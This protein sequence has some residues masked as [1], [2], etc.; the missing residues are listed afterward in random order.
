LNKLKLL[1][2]DYWEHGRV[3]TN[4]DLALD[5][6]AAMALGFALGKLL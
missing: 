1:F 4:G 2:R 3:T 6:L 5:C